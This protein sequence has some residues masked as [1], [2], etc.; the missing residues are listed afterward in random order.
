MTHIV[1]APELG[2]C[3][4]GDQFRARPQP[5]TFISTIYVKL[6]QIA[7]YYVHQFNVQVSITH[8][9]RNKKLANIF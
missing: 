3:L 7:L 6:Y 2:L 5:N 9:Y 8:G 4:V 1:L